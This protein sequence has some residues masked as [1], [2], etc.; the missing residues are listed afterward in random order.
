MFTEFLA[1][2]YLVFL[3]LHLIAMA[4]GLGG[5]TIS[6]ILF[7]K[8]LKD[9][10]ISLREEKILRLMSSVIWFAVA[11]ALITGL[12]LYIPQAELLNT[13]PKF[14]A[15]VTV[16]G[17]VIINGLALNWFIAP[18]LIK[19]S[20]HKR[21][22]HEKGELHHI[23]KLA[24][25]LGAISITSWYATLVMAMV[26]KHSS[27]AYLSLVASYLLILAVVVMLSQWFDHWM[28]NSASKKS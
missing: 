10:R 19:I 26:P 18:Q 1:E 11:F 7:F 14:L 24:F 15:K 5:A 6:D 16:F 2:Y 22:R 28:L 21:H 13:I 23:R 8:F 25:A 27:F 3:T 9:F 4:L 12:A 17:V 20:F